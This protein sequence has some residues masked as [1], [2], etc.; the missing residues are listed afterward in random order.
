GH[1][2]LRLL[3]RFARVRLRWQPRQIFYTWTLGQWLRI[4]MVERRS[5]R[6]RFPGQLSEPS[7]EVLESDQQVDGRL[8]ELVIGEV[9]YSRA[10][11]ECLLWQRA[12]RKRLWICHHL[13]PRRILQQP[14]REY[15]FSPHLSGHRRRHEHF[16]PGAL[17]AASIC[18]GGND[19]SL[20]QRR[21]DVRI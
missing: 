14:A 13:W 12:D 17:V 5:W 19:S 20:A 9:L 16:V 8:F 4:H 10:S 2:R 7:F 15:D 6:D 1:Q 18:P 11:V 21:L 3:G